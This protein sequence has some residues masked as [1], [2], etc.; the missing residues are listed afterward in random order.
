ME[1]YGDGGDLT[2]VGV[3]ICLGV[4]TPTDMVSRL[5]DAVTAIVAAGFIDITESLI[6]D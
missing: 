1:N 6:L 2:L 3:S 4:S 5:N